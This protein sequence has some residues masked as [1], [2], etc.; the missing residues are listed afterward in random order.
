M[1]ITTNEP[2]EAAQAAAE[3]VET[4]RQALAAAEAAHQAIDREWREVGARR[5]T[6]GARVAALHNRLL[7]ERRTAESL[8]WADPELTRQLGEA[9]QVLRAA[10]AELAQVEREVRPAIARRH[11]HLSKQAL[12]IADV[13]R[14]ARSLLTTSLP[15]GV[16]EDAVGRD[17]R[18]IQAVETVRAARA[19]RS[20]L[21]RLL[22]RR[23]RQAEYETTT[24]ARDRERPR[25]QPATPAAR[26]DRIR[27]R[28]GLD[29]PAEVT[30]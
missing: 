9:D 16:I 14:G 27:S 30:R 26:L 11:A 6:A 13:P 20:R 23:A 21:A 28:L 4:T 15:S 3:A 29:T 18:H 5:H 1:T 2:T 8:R 12:D 22:D 17:G 24:A 25:A 10:E 19:E 7:Q